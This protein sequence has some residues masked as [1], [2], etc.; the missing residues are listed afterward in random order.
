MGRAISLEL[1]KH[2][3]HVAIADADL[4]GAKNTCEELRTLG[5]KA[6]AYQVMLK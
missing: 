2:G 5:V 3:C 1:A 4:A 6:E